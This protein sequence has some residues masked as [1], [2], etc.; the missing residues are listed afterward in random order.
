MREHIRLLVAN[1]RYTDAGKL[2]DRIPEGARQQM[3]GPLYSE[4]LFQSK[5][6]DAALKQARTAT[7]NDPKNAQSQ[8]WYGQLLARSSQATDVTPQRRSQ[9]MGDAIKAMQRATELQPEFPD[10]WFALINYHAMQK[11]QAQAQ[12]TMR[13]AQLC[14]QWR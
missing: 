10:A 4:I 8:Y 6:V 14:A 2:L 1:G 5:Q 3:L 13:D 11:D 12:K 7:E 9:I